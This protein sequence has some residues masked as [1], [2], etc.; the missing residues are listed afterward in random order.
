[1]KR[2]GEILLDWGVIAVAELHT[3]LEACQRT[4]GR[5][6]TQLLKFG[7]VDE[8][9][10]VEALSEQYGVPSVTER[11]LRRAPLEIRRT[12]PP[13]VC[14]RLQAVP[15]GRSGDELRVALANPRDPAAIEEIAEITGVKIE[16]H[17]AT[18]SAIITTISEL[19]E[20]LVEVVV[21]G[22]AAPA[23]TPVPTLEWEQLWAPPQLHPS[24]LLRVR[25]R[26]RSRPAGGPAVATFPGLAPIVQ[27]VGA[28]ADHDLDEVAFREGLGLVRHRD[29]VAVLLL[30]FAAHYL[31]RIGLFAVHRG[32][33]VGWMARGHGVAVDDV[34]SF[35]VSL[36]RQ[37]LFFDLNEASDRYLGPMPPGVNN[38]A[39]AAVLGDPRPVS[40]LG[41]AIRIKERTVAFLV[42][43]NPGEATLA[44]PV[45]EL[46]A[47]CR[48]AGAALEILIIRHKILS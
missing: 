35:A 43:D 20:D 40:I 3:G 21:A 28:V 44:V 27:G 19:D 45:E 11:V 29:E 48:R 26:L 14:R 5:L 30:R 18:E 17:V 6:G 24:R 15:F 31:A 1:M 8:Y 4:G 42:G 13:G 2:L 46:A 36:D 39:L 41:L 47:A 12:L 7:F 9:S 25:R 38:D 32:V 34:Q 10:L 23:S 22:D 33:A 37:S 16:P